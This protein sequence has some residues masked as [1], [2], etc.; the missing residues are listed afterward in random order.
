MDLSLGSSNRVLMGVA[1]VGAFHWS[2]RWSLV[3]LERE[4]EIK[5]IC[6]L[7]SKG[8]FVIFIFFIYKKRSCQWWGESTRED[9]YERIQETFILF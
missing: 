7:L 1:Y 3:G 2:F 9:V 4:K 5:K 8:I 6:L